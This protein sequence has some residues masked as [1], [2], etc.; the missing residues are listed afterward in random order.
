MSLFVLGGTTPGG[1]GGTWGSITG[2]LSDQ[3]DLQAALDDKWDLNGNLIGAALNLYFGNTDA[4]SSGVTI[5]G[6]HDDVPWLF[7]DSGTRELRD[8]NDVVAINFTNGT[9][10][11]RKM[12]DASGLLSISWGESGR[13]LA[14]NSGEQIIDFGTAVLIYPG[15]SYIPAI[16][17][18]NGTWSAINNETRV[19]I[20]LSTSQL[21]GDS[22]VPVFSWNQ[23]GSELSFFNTGTVTQRTASDALTG[24][25]ALGLFVTGGANYYSM[26]RITGLSQ[27][28]I[29]FG[30]AATAFGSNTNFNYDFNNTRLTVGSAQGG[31]NVAHLNAVSTSA[32]NV[33]SRF[34]GATSQSGD[35]ARW[36]N[37]SNTTLS[38]VN[39]AGKFSIGTASAPTA[40]LMLGA[41]TTTAASAPLKM[42][43]GSLMTTPEAGAQEF[44]TDKFYTTI[45]TG[46]ARKEFT[47]NDIALTSG[48]VP[49][50][51]TN[52][53]LSDSTNLQF[54]S[55]SGTLTPLY[56]GQT[57]TVGNFILGDGGSQHIVFGTSSGSNIATATNQKLGF[58]NV[59]PIVQPAN[60][61]AI[62][63]VLA[64]V[65]LRN[66]GGVALFDTDIKANVVGKGLYIK[67]G[68]NAT[69]GV[70]TLV[71]GTAVV[72]TTKV[73]ASSRIQLTAQA[74]GTITVPVGYAVSA[75]T[76]GTSFTILSGNVADTSTVA[77][78]IFEP[79]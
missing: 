63:T 37:S 38:L 57:T 72:S 5:T 12:F 77:W 66:S 24:L 28:L 56:L 43:S 25:E 8:Q 27:Y 51:T 70:T 21:L 39:S 68:S 42:V 26:S 46:T 79:A 40:K 9:S 11:A 62:D 52:G 14:N 67:E 23:S 19:S 71:A 53:R 48:R 13:Y 33:V 32:A 44:L 59:T 76:A 31:N 69:M 58:W 6:L 35:L 30:T 50:T 1:G 10:S 16:D 41:G 36:I 45:T 61:V 3:T 64:N 18:G 29:P 47:L 15:G 74:L 49:F 17:W 4:I 75:R 55:A 22:N 60:T 65:G 54:N 34:V 73:T 20:G 78:T 2:T 7:L